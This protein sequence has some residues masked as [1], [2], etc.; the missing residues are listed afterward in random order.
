MRG[1]PKFE[2]VRQPLKLRRISVTGDAA[3]GCWAIEIESRVDTHSIRSTPRAILVNNTKFLSR[4]RPMG[5]L[6]TWRGLSPRPRRAANRDTLRN[7]RNEFVASWSPTW[8]QLKP[9]A[10][11]GA[12]SVSA[13][14]LFDQDGSPEI[15]SGTPG[16]EEISLASV[17]CRNGV[18]GSTVWSRTGRL[19]FP[20]GTVRSIRGTQYAVSTPALRIPYKAAQSHLSK[21]SMLLVPFGGKLGAQ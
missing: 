16:S 10:F 15:L 17:A 9:S 21:Q 13:A 8:P 2:R 7:G 6:A 3:S 18:T 5:S 12:L 11:G 1:S 19:R 4:L 20:M 14:S